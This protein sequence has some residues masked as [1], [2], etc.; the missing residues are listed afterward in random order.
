MIGTVLDDPVL[1]IRGLSGDIIVA[2]DVPQL[3][4]VWQET[5]GGE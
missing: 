3:K 5:W 4:A 1:R 2:A